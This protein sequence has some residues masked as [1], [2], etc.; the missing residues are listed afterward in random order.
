MCGSA[1]QS[2]ALDNTPLPL[3]EGV[4]GGLKRVVLH[5]L[6]SHLL[7]GAGDLIPVFG[8]AMATEAE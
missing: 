1:W 7:K 8:W 4:G 3:R 6:L 2:G 5:S